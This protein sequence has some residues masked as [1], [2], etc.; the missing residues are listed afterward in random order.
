MYFPTWVE[1]VLFKGAHGMTHQ[2]PLWREPLSGRRKH[3]RSSLAQTAE[4]TAQ[5]SK[6]GDGGAHQTHSPLT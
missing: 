3:L 6:G 4:L 5:I 1:C 2:G